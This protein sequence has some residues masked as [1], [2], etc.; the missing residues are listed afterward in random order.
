MT[1]TTIVEQ[2]SVVEQRILI[3]EASNEDLSP[4]PTFLRAETD[5]G[6]RTAAQTFGGVD[7]SHYTEYKTFFQAAYAMLASIWNGYQQNGFMSESTME[8]Y[9]RE[10]YRNNGDNTTKTV[11]STDC[12]SG[13]AAYEALRA[14]DRHRHK[15][16]FVGKHQRS[17]KFITGYAMA[18]ATRLFEAHHNRRITDEAKE[19]LAARSAAHARHLYEIR[20]K[21]THDLAR[22]SST[23][24]FASTISQ[25]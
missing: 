4:P 12:I 18:E 19:E 21:E 9:H 25:W 15:R 13:A 17:S 7:N 8:S 16:G 10:L 6:V 22:R 5:F 24:S 23:T 2:R 3:G 14:Y 1:S 20:H 11:V